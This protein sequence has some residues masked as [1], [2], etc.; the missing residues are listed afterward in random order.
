MK[1]KGRVLFQNVCGAGWER[2][3]EE[4]MEGKLWSGCRINEKVVNK[5]NKNTSVNKSSWNCLGPLHVSGDDEN[6][7]VISGTFLR[8]GWKPSPAHLLPTHFFPFYAILSFPW[9]TSLVFWK[10]ASSTMRSDSCYVSQSLCW[11]TVLFPFLPCHG[12]AAGL[13]KQ[14]EFMPWYFNAK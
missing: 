2:E 13:L 4:R 3:Q 12:V 6:S 8:S 10:V 1:G 11:S 9:A 7:R 14:V 5:I